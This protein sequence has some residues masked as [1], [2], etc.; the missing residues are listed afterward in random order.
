MDIAFKGHRAF[1]TTGEGV[2]VVDVS[3]PAAPR[4]VTTIGAPAAQPISRATVWLPR[5]ISP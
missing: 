3:N 1:I 2:A 5:V 4:L